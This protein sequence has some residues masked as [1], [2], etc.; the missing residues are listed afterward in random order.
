MQYSGVLP[1]TNPAGCNRSRSSSRLQA[2]KGLLDRDYHSI[3]LRSSSVK[4][5]LTG[6]PVRRCVRMRLTFLDVP[7]KAAAA[8]SMA[9]FATPQSW[10]PIPPASAKASWLAP[11]KVNCQLYFFCCSS[12]ISLIRALENSLLEFS[13]PSVTMT[14]MTSPGRSCSGIFAKA[15]AGLVDRPP[16]RVEQRRAASGHQLVV[17]DSLDRD[18]AVDELVLGVELHQGQQGIARLLGLLPD[19]SVDAALGVGADFLHRAAAV[20]YQGDVGQIGFHV[21]SPFKTEVK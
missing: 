6:C 8:L 9:K 11:R 10:M 13:W 7:A 4:A 14:K 12:I 2:S 18:A 20:D 1:G 17:A 21:P 15:L 5:L 19:E 16:Y 3:S